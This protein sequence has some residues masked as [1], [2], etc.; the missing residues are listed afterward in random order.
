MFQVSRKA[1]DICSSW[2]TKGLAV[3]KPTGFVLNVRK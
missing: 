3:H 2:D 1:G